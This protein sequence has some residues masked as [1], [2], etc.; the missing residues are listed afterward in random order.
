MKKQEQK[1]SRPMQ[2]TAVYKVNRSDQ[3]L[4]FLLRKCNTSRNNVKSLLARRQVLVNGSVVTQFD[5]PLAKDDEVKL[6]KTSVQGNVAP[7]AKPSPK[8]RERVRLP[9]IKIIYEDEDFIA[10]DK[11][12]GLLSVES[13][14]ETECAF[15]CVF[16][17]LKRQ[18]KN[19]RPFLLHRIDKETSGVLVFAK[20]PKV[21]SMLKMHWN[22]LVTLRE[23]YAVVEGVMEKKE[24]TL[25][26]YLKENK[27][28]LVYATKD[29]SGQKAITHYTVV[30]ANEQYS[31]LRV[32]IDT[33]RKNQIRVQM[34]EIGH[35]VVGDDK[36]GHTKN[37]LKRLGLHASKL[38]F[39]HPVKKTEQLFA[40]PTPSAFRALFGQ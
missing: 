26:S 3:L 32:R 40:A 25:V 38:S 17:Y 35:P 29:P 20:N 15:A 39:L 23:Y 16:E 13:D 4:E 21:H 24:D 2:Y 30:A 37:P 12:A 10:I 1:T 18:D 27:N 6:A 19:A 31:L 9:Q 28:N 8:T 36:Y 11:P 22:E 14:K 34:Q 33:G 7:S 5:F